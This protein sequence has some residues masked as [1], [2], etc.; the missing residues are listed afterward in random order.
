MTTPQ[1]GPETGLTPDADGQI[2]VPCDIGSIPTLSHHPRAVLPV[3]VPH[4]VWT[5]YLDAQRTLE[6]ASLK[7]VAHMRRTGQHLGP[8]A[9]AYAEMALYYDEEFDEDDHACEMRR[10]RSANEQGSGQ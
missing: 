3:K 2:T 5:E 7:I 8:S 1:P 9:L 4:E 10:A 6:T